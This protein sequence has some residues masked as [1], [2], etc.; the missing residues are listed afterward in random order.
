[1]N[2]LHVADAVRVRKS[3]SAAFK[4][5]VGRERL[6]WKKGILIPRKIIVK[7]KKG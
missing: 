1:M 7:K 4:I 2:R 6:K 5:L 3:R